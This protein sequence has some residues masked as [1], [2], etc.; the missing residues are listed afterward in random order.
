MT[1]LRLFGI[2]IQLIINFAYTMLRF[3]IPQD[4]QRADRILGPL[5]LK[6]LIILA[7]GGGFAYIIYIILA[8]AY[9]WEVWLWPVGLIS[10]ITLGFAF[11]KIQGLSLFKFFIYFT[12]FLFIPRNRVWNKTD[13]HVYFSAFAPV[14]NVA[15]KESNVPS[16]PELTHEQKMKKLEEISKIL[17]TNQNG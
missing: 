3:K 8:K 16:G 10:I 6:Q 5:T 17:N 7:G 4:V 1:K 12:Q 14:T 2:I 11:L 13:G 15:S 9:F